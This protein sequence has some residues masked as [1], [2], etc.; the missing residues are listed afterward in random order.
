MEVI[1]DDERNIPT[2]VNGEDIPHNNRVY[3]G[4]WCPTCHVRPGAWCQRV[5]T[6]TGER[7]LLR[8]LHK[9]R[10]RR[11]EALDKQGWPDA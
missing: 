4:V 2:R 3:R 8:S 9:S 11:L 7:G 5:I 6:S 10:Y 1:R